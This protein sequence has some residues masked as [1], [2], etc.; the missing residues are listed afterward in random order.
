MPFTNELPVFDDA[1]VLSLRGPRHQVDPWR[2]HAF[3]NEPE[4]T[5]A[6]TVEDVSTIFLTNREC[7]FRCLMCDLWKFTTDERVPAG[8]IPAQIA[9]A[10]GRLPQAAQ[11]KLY[12]AGNFFDAQ[13]IPPS[14]RPAIARLVTTF[15]NVII[16]CHPRL[17]GHSCAEFQQMLG[18]RL[19]VALGL[20]T[21]HPDVLPRLNKRMTLAM[22]E[23]AVRF[24]R[25]RGMGVR[26]FILLRP[27][28][29]GEADGVEWAKKSLSYAFDLGVECCTVIPTRAGNGA[30]EYLQERGHFQTPCLQSLEEVLAYGLDLG[31]GRVFADLWDIERFYP[32][33][34]CGPL[35]TA[36]LREINLTQRV[37]EPIECVCM[38]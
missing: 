9:W 24:L 26:A 29:L 8:A 17:I 31:A 2:P 21:I 1:A 38:R 13:A 32:C 12:N 4:R 28:F 6:G 37:P 33:P 35:R 10:L 18:G 27:P 34:T 7:P 15:Q 16:E 36:R 23:D 25:D 30:M 20:E 19:E 5:A 11:V 14:D 3:F 22:F